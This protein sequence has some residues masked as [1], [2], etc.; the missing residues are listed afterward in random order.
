ME[1]FNENV[2]IIPEGYNQP[3][4]VTTLLGGIID[5]V[6]TGLKYLQLIAKRWWLKL[7]LGIVITA[8]ESFKT[9]YPKQ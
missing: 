3:V 6:I 7:A 1:T 2:I 4:P 8:L 5:T 9:Q